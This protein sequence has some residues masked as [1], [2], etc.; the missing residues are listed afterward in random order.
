VCVGGVCGCVW[1]CVW[2]C[3]CVYVCVCV[4]V[5]M[6]VTQWESSEASYS[7]NFSDDINNGCSN[8]NQLESNA[9]FT[10]DNLSPL[11]GILLL[12]FKT[13]RETEWA[14]L[15]THDR[16]SNTQLG[17]RRGNLSSRFRTR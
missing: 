3:V 2:V 8:A 7:N 9:Q 11:I 4:C 17:G 14:P 13:S 15:E 10:T 12:L 5:D 1:V 16:G 6:Y